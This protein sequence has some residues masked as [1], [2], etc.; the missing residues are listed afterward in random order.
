[1][2]LLRLVVD[3]GHSIFHTYIYKEKLNRIQPPE[4][5]LGF[6]WMN[7]WQ[8]SFD[9]HLTMFEEFLRSNRTGSTSS[10]L[11]IIDHVDSG[12]EFVRSQSRLRQ[13]GRGWREAKKIVEIGYS[14]SS[15]SNPMIQLSDL[16]AF[17]LK[18]YFE[19]KIPFSD[20]WHEEAHNFFKECK[21]SIWPKVQFKNLSF[22]KLKVKDTYIQHF[23]DIRKPN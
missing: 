21:E 8:S 22:Q 23:K 18:K 4:E 20:S 9:L 10:G 11:V 3:R 14:V 5:G 15:H 12:F 17:T 19:S 7:P 2:D 13:Q 6:N 1:M 16:I